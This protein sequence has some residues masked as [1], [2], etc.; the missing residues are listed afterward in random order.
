M[1]RDDLLKD[2]FY[3]QE[4]RKHREM[5]DQFRPDKR[6]FTG[7]K[8]N[9]RRMV[10]LDLLLLVILAGVLY[11]FILSR[12][13]PD[14]RVGDFTF[15][16]NVFFSGETAMHMLAVDAKEE[17]QDISALLEVQFYQ[18]GTAL[19]SP[20]VDLVPVPGRARQFSREWN[21]ASDITDMECIVFLDGKEIARFRQEY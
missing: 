21:L 19:G 5:L 1:D 13:G 12:F 9:T 2:S 3:E 4:K 16:Y 20:L 15:H 7:K 18:N 11:P 8:R 14:R 10:L 17:P 6:A